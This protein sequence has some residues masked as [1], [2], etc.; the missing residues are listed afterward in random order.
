MLDVEVTQVDPTGTNTI[1]DVFR[2]EGL[3]LVQ[4]A[5]LNLC[6]LHLQVHS[7]SDILSLDGKGI[8]GAVL[9]G[10]RSR[11][12]GLLWPKTEVPTSWWELWRSSVNDFI[13]PG[14]GQMT[15]KSSHQRSRAWTNSKRDLVRHGEIL[16][17]AMHS[18]TRA[19]LYVECDEQVGDL[20]IP[21]DVM[22]RRGRL[23]MVCVG[24]PYCPKR[25]Q[26]HMADPT[27]T[28]GVFR[29]RLSKLGRQTL[30][31]L[32]GLPTEDFTIKEISNELEA[33]RLYAASDGSTW[34]E[35]NAFGICLGSGTEP[36]RWYTANEVDGD[37]VASDRS[38]LCGLL[39]LVE[40][41]NEIAEMENIFPS[42]TVYSDNMYAI[43]FALSP[44]LGSTPAWA[45]KRN[46]DLK[47]ELK[48]ELEKGRVK[49]DF[50][51]VK[52]HQD[53]N[54]KYE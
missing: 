14:V 48:A 1:M 27:T 9:K 12:S 2:K 41:L 8:L 51:H 42:T 25:T 23:R 32:E 24:K 44:H 34:A 46:A 39:A 16:Y 47:I 36:K 45:D 38:E 17:R 20:E 18:Q 53:R 15:W 30:R 13:T 54:T 33:G 29:R 28:T 6:R 50:V 19:K 26:R 37:P 21:C 35:R 11:D 7:V 43:N 31:R 3:S 10:E 22:N 40:Y 4:M 52:G 49:Y 5:R